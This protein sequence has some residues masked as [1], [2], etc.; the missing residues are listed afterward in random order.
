MPGGASEDHVLGA[1]DEAELV[2]ALELLTTQRRLKGKSKSGSRLT[3]GKR[4]ERIA[5]RIRRLFRS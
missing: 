2:H 4:I 3:A 1:L 5:A